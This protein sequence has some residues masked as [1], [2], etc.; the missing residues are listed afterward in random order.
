MSSLSKKLCIFKFCFVF[1]AIFIFSYYITVYIM[2]FFVC[3]YNYDNFSEVFGDRRF[4]YSTTCV[5]GLVTFID[6]GVAKISI[7]FGLVK[8][9]SKLS[10]KEIYDEEG[11][12]LVERDEESIEEDCK[13]I[14]EEEA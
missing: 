13:L 12:S 10:V 7:L 11:V 9:G 8:E 1:F 5:V 3:F 4:V 6:V 14:V 2:S